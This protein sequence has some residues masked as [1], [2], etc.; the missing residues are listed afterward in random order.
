MLSVTMNNSTIN[1]DFELS[2]LW[3]VGTFVYVR[4]DGKW[5]GTRGGKVGN[6]SLFLTSG[7]YRSVTAQK[8]TSNRS[9]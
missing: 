8:V 4:K 6:G 1:T 5:S 7:H 2:D 3:Q 9:A